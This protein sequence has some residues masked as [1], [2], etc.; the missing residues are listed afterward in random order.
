M[1]AEND[2]RIYSIQVWYRLFRYTHGEHYGENQ[3]RLGRG[4]FIDLYVGT[5]PGLLANLEKLQNRS[6][7]LELK[8]A[9]LRFH[10]RWIEPVIRLP[11]LLFLPCLMKH[12]RGLKRNVPT[13]QISRHAHPQHS[14]NNR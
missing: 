12:L 7:A 4:Y 13:E 8:L 14:K 5:I 10:L 1:E 9:Q 11:L 2:N 3:I 6:L